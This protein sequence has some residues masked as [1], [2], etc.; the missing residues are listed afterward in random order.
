MA[1]ESSGPHRGGGLRSLSVVEIRRR[2]LAVP[3]V[4]SA[5][6]L[7]QLEADPR[8]GV[9]AL[10]RRFL[11]QR[12]R[13]ERE[14]H[15]IDA[16]LDA[17]RRLWAR[18]ARRVAGVDEVGMGPLAGPV[19]AA[20]VIFPPE[21]RIRGVDD[22]KRLDRE[23]RE[24]L[25]REIRARAAGVSI[26]AADVAEIDRLNV[27]QAGRLAMQRAV[28]G[29]EE[30]PDH[31]LVDGRSVPGL[32]CAQDRVDQ[33]DAKVF[34]IAA[35]SIVAKVY[36]DA[37]MAR[38]DLQHPGYGLV[39]HKGYGTPEHLDALRRLGPSPIHRRSFAPV[40]ELD[41]PS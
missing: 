38:L 19:V 9:K 14:R 16:L 27:Y 36:R 11:R 5:D 35:A 34:V 37:W 30:A 20:A 1:T 24:A 7:A 31:A 23:R 22:S 8:A 12:E 33:G 4:P 3:G 26:G 21:T 17:E 2:F 10:H 28:L 29:L 13:E 32:A 25:A 41:R 18:G 6:L 40:A 15:R 39:R